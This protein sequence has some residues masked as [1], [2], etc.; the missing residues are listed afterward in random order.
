MEE[1]IAQNLKQNIPA[2]AAPTIA[3]P[4]VGDPA[5]AN[6]EFSLDELTQYKLA[7]HFDEQY[8]PTDT[9]A[10]QQLTDIFKII[11]D[12]IGTTDY[13]YVVQHLNELKR[14]LGFNHTENARFKLYSWLKLD[15]K[16]SHIE[17]E[18]SNV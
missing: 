15:N 17:M 9:I 13:V 5:E 11:S 12:R 16:R 1:Q 14:M 4:V 7:Q 10:N 8:Q 3:A 18:M 6:V 2:P